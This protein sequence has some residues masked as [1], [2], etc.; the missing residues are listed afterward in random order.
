MTSQKKSKINSDGETL[1]FSKEQSPHSS[2][3]YDFANS[4]LSSRSKSNTNK[5]WDID[6][7]KKQYIPTESALNLNSF[8]IFDFESRVSHPNSSGSRGQRISNQQKC[9]QDFSSSTQ[10]SD[11]EVE[12]EIESKSFLSGRLVMPRK[13]TLSNSSSSSSNEDEDHKKFEEELKKYQTKQ[14]LCELPKSQMD[15]NMLLK[16]EKAQRTQTHATGKIRINRKQSPTSAKDQLIPIIEERNISPQVIS[17]K[18]FQVYFI[19]R[20]LIDKR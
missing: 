3:F 20:S 2:I 8:P 14:K 9:P 18:L 1:K 13:G 16:G 6:P 5:S 11:N 4:P 15:A 17:C 7:F 12:V 19:Y 10:T